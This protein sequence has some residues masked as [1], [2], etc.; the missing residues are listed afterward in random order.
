MISREAAAVVVLDSF[1]KAS[2]NT[3]VE[4]GRMEG[5]GVDA[6]YQS[7]EHLSNQVCLV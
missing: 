6:H 4:G 2:C 7:K 5:R 3:V 1:Q